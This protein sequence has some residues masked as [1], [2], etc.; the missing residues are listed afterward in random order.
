MELDFDKCGGLIPAVV[1]DSETGKVLM[2][3]YVN[4]EAFEKT[5]STGKATFW[6]RSRNSLWVKGATSG[7]Y[8]SIVEIL[9]DCD[10]DSII[11]KVRQEG[12]GVACHLGYVSCFFRKLENGDWV[13]NGEKK[14]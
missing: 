6:S 4:R 10:A 9:T 11:Y 3:A 2:L 12:K 13:D 14:L 8:Q 7:N 5:V 1:Q